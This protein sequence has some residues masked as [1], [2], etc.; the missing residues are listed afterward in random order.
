MTAPLHFAAF[1]ET[2][3][4]CQCDAACT[5]RPHIPSARAAA[6]QVFAQ[7]NVK[8]VLWSAVFL[9][10]GVFAGLSYVQLAAFDRALAICGGPV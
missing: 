7:Q 5:A 9:L 8:I 4:D 3:P 6:A 2:W 10:L 1:C